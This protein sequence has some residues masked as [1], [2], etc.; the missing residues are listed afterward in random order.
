MSP[1]L[2][3]SLCAMGNICRHSIISF[4]FGDLLSI[5]ARI[6]TQFLMM[7]HSE[8]EAVNA[9]TINMF[10]RHFVEF[11]RCFCSKTEH[12]MGNFATN[13]IEHVSEMELYIFL[14]TLEMF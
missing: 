11:E 7:S 13:I 14:S 9:A 12:F 3:L 2:V 6:S 5:E 4:N 8:N 1:Y 10:T